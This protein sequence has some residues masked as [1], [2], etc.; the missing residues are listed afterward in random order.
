MIT[1]HLMNA[2][3][4]TGVALVGGAVKERRRREILR[5]GRTLL[6]KRGLAALQMREVARRAG[7][8]AG[9]VYLYF[10]TKESLFAEM[11]ADRLD[12]MAAEL[13]PTLAAVSDLE[14]LF[15]AFATSYRDV[16]VEFGRNLDVL[17]GISDQSRLEP[18][19]RDHLIAATSRLL[20]VARVIVERTV[21]QLEPATA[22][23]PDLVLSLLWSTI[24]GL[25]DHFTSIRHLM[26]RYVWDDTARFA[27]RT[28]ISGL[29][30]SH[31]TPEK[32]T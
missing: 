10:P 18:A 2:V 6:R 27:A 30:Y 25:A 11:F 14:E 26:H 16:Y 29:V 1:V 28:V 23:D 15:I 22:P 17:A 20:D 8:A 21:A 3:Q 31:T 5:A 19:I 32:Q 24:T 13:E 12:Q 9:T 4:S 7:V